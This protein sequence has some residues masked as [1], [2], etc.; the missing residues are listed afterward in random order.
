MKNILFYISII[1]STLL[2]CY[3]SYQEYIIQTA[4]AVHQ[5]EINKLHNRAIVQGTYHI[6]DRDHGT[7]IHTGTFYDCCDKV[8]DYETTVGEC[9]I[10]RHDE[11]FVG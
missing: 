5:E 9:V 3:A 4:D 6:Y 11:E 8:Y 2:I 10:L 7:I 1:I